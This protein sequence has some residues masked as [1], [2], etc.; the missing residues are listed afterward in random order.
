MSDSFRCFLGFEAFA[1]S[2]KAIQ[3]NLNCVERF[4]L[5]CGNGS[6]PH[7]SHSKGRGHNTTDIQGL[8]VK[9]RKKSSSVN[10]NNPVG[11]LST[12]C[13]FIQSI[14]FSSRPKIFKAL[15]DCYIFHRGNPKPLKRLS[16]PG[17]MIHQSKDQL[18]LT[19]GICCTHKARNIFSGHELFQNPKL[20]F[21]TGRNIILPVYRED[22]QVCISPFAVFRIIGF[23]L[24]KFHQMPH[25]PADHISVSL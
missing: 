7:D 4:G 17:F 25:T 10:A 20:F 12:Q 18:A 13:C 3:S 22:R 24:C 8:P 1:C 23:R 9:G 16:A 14:I 2:R 5:E 6:F 15:L 11:S 21:R 19:T